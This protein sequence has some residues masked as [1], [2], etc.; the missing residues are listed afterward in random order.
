MTDEILAKLPFW[1]QRILQ[2]S[3]Q[4]ESSLIPEDDEQGAAKHDTCSLGSD[5]AERREPGDL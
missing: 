4:R 5:R 1:A 3:E 2:W